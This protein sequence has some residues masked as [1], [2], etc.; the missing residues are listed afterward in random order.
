MTND[1]Y[2][3]LTEEEW[4]QGKASSKIITKLDL[5]DGFV[6]LSTATQLNASLS[7]YFS[8]ESKVIL[9]QINL[10][11][12]I[13]NLKFEDV[14]IANNRGGKFPHFYGILN[15]DMILKTWQLERS[16]FCLPKEVLLQAEQ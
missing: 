12:I 11:K 15:T 5:K 2:K 3:I 10:S 7:L 13:N 14:S 1:V 8:N 9:A 6:H 16:A 4:R